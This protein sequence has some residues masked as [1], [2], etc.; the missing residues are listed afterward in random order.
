MLLFILAAVALGYYVSRDAERQNLGRGAVGLARKGSEVLAKGTAWFRGTDEGAV[1]GRQ[2]VPADTRAPIAV[3][4]APCQPRDSH[5]IDDRLV[6]FIGTAERT[7]WCAFYDLEHEEVAKTLIGKHRAGVEVRIVSDSEY[8]DRPALRNCIKAGIAV[9]LDDRDALM[10]NKFCVV[11][12]KRVWTGS[13][14]ATAACMYRNNNNSLWIESEPLAA[15]YAAEFNEMFE[16]RRF[17]AR[18]PRNTPYPEVRVGDMVVE[19]YFAPEDGVRR[20]ILQELRGAKTSID[21]MAF[22]FTSKEL[23]EAMRDRTTT[24]VRVRGLF[25][26]RNAKSKPS[27]D[28]ELADAGA[29]IYLDRNPYSMHH[30]VM[31]IDGE[32]VI[33][34]SYNFS[35]SAEN[36]NDENLLVIHAPAIAQEFLKEF[37][38]LVR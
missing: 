10:H 38:R 18:S 15:D 36:R 34:G 8:K 11:D 7:I 16:G 29:T 13:T 35:D 37:E 1:G 2:R 26:S 19:C 9:V 33:T 24:G 31:V 12:R 3:Y 22:S 32:T 23:A 4:F 28:E 17:G 5:G 21:F 30:K 27:K 25:E 20:R 6:E 14:N